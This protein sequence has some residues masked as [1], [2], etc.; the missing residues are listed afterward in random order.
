MTEDIATNNNGPTEN[1]EE[2]GKYVLKSSEVS[3]DSTNSKKYKKGIIYLSKIPPHMNVTQLTEFMSRFGEVGRVYLMPK[4]RKPGEK[5]PAKQFTEGWV[6]F[7]KKKVAKQ[8]AAQYNNTQIDCRKRSK[9]YDFI[10]NFKYLPRFKWIHLSERLAYEKQAHRHKLRAEIAE[11][12]REALYFSNNLDI[13]ERIG[14]KN[15][16]KNNSVNTQKTNTKKMDSK[17]KQNGK[18]S[19]TKPVEDRKQFL[20]SLFS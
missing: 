15:K 18:N 2:A 13:A 12:K 11:A 6:E 16:K 9:H 7:L 8:V 17:G 3:Q 19:N 14:K 20:T 4:K 1:V 10:W 5:K